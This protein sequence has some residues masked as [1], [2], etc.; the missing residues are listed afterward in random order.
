VRARVALVALLVGPSAVVA[1]SAFSASE[2][3]PANV[4]PDGSVADV[5][6][7]LATVD[8]SIEDAGD[9]AIGWG[10]QQLDCDAAGAFDALDA[11]FDGG[12]FSADLFGQAIQAPE[13]LR[14]TDLMAGSGSIWFTDSRATPDPAT[15]GARITF[16][17]R[18]TVDAGCQSGMGFAV[19]WDTTKPQS[20]N[21]FGT[22]SGM[23]T[24]AAFVLETTSFSPKARLAALATCQPLVP[25]AVQGVTDLALDPDG[26]LT[27]AWHL[28]ELDVAPKRVIWSVTS[29]GLPM[30]TGDYDLRT[31]ETSTGIGAAKYLGIGAQTGVGDAGLPMI[32]SH[33]IRN[34]RIKRCP[35]KP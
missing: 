23:A 22:C 13:G 26:G 5:A 18:V 14:L 12:A 15:P 3:A 7:A 32:A 6:D 29:T 10:S 28:V 27:S 9:G 1:C 24:G 11:P 31:S 8:T 20:R 25:G 30:A 33:T 2:D 16:E 21:G 4:A 17:V 35:L 19:A 34:L